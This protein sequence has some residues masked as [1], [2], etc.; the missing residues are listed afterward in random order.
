MISGSFSRI[1]CMRH[2]PVVEKYQAAYEKYKKNQTKLLIWIATNDWVKEQAKQNLVD[3]YF[4]LKLYNKVHKME[5]KLSRICYSPRGI[6]KGLAAVKKLAKEAGVC[7]DN[8]KL[9]LMMQAIWQI[10]LPWS[11]SWDQLLMLNLQMQFIKLIFFFSHDK[12]TA[13]SQKVNK[14]T[15]TVVDVASRFKAAEPLS[16]KDSSEVSKAFQTIYR[17]GPLRWPKV[18][19][20]DPRHEFMGEV[21]THDMRIRRGNVNIHRNQGIIEWFN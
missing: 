5:R 1:M 19:Q 14:Y 16:S 13:R 4:A 7:E 2:D 11:I 10:Y 8:T 6:W 15:L 12:A 17:H 20:V 18:L 21:T 9:W 3:T